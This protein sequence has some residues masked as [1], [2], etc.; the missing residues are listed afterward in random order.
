MELVF[1]IRFGAKNETREAMEEVEKD[2]AKMSSGIERSTKKTQAAFARMREGIGKAGEAVGSAMKRLGVAAAAAAAG[3]AAIVFKSSETQDAVFLLGQRLGE[4]A[5]N[6]TAL[7]AVAAG[8]AGVELEEFGTALSDLSARAVNQTDVFKKWGIQTKTTGG[9]VLSAGDLLDNVADRMSKLSTQAEKVALADELMGEAGR[10]LVPM[11]QDG[12]A[13]LDEQKRAAIEAGLAMTD[14]ESRAG[15]ALQTQLGAT[16]GALGSVGSAMTGQLA[17]ALTVITKHVQDVA[18]ELAGWIRTNQEL[19]QSGIQEFFVFLA[20]SVIPALATGVLTLSKAWHGWRL[21]IDFVRLALNSFF[22]FTLEGVDAV[23]DKLG[24]L[25]RLAGLDEL[26]AK[27]ESARGAVQGLGDE[28]G[29]SAEEA[30]QGMIETQKEMRD[31]EAAIGRLGVKGSEAM[32]RVAKETAEATKGLKKTETQAKKTNAAIAAG[33]ADA[34]LKSLQARRAAYERSMAL[35][36]MYLENALANEERREAI[37]D[38]FAERAK[39]KTEAL[40][41]SVQTGFQSVLDVGVEAFQGIGEEVDGRT[42]TMSDAF[43]QFFGKLGILIAQS[44]A[45]FAMAQA[46]EALLVKTSAATQVTANAAKAGSGAAASQAG[47][48]IVGPALAVAAMAAIVSTVLGLLGT[49]NTGGIVGGSGPNID[50]RL[51][52][53]T[54]GEGILDREATAHVLRS[55]S[56]RG[57]ATSAP[58]AQPAGSPGSERSS[59]SGAPGTSVSIGLLAMPTNRTDIRRTLRDLD[60]ELREMERSG[61]SRRGRRGSRG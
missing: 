14:F 4:T 7:G 9:Q 37:L 50:S 47:I 38:A 1:G 30:A 48:P 34:A 58:V 29:R 32:R 15:N 36:D 6:I 51:I 21:I 13:A 26:S 49:F 23:L 28:F 57:G 35:D 44:F 10:R 46:K 25:A 55:L 52:M 42:K 33:S 41:D 16:A 56:G 19:I 12:S 54:P 53:A 3:L 40:I 39:A 61:L 17:P 18:G 8:A 20:D 45:Q 24:D 2:S 5:E 31:T 60:S 59:T 11:L 27:V 43:A 22:E